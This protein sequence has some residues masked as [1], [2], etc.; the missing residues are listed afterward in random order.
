MRSVRP[1]LAGATGGDDHCEGRDCDCDPES[2][3][4]DHD[5]T[6]SVE[7]PLW[8]RCPLFGTRGDGRYTQGCVEARAG[9]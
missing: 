2:L 6:S 5:E 9:P 4:L 3:K 1:L 8:A 7:E